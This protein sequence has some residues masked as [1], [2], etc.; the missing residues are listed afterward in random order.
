MAGIRLTDCFVFGRGWGGGE[1][2]RIIR[3]FIHSFAWGG[4][5]F[6][7]LC[8][9]LKRSTLLTDRLLLTVPGPLLKL[10]AIDL[11]VSTVF[12]SLQVIIVLGL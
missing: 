10:E 3:S 5:S 8:S 4:V 9:P 2:G 1:E 11:T 6:G 7:F 12:Q